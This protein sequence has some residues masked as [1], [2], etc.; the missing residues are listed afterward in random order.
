M[1]TDVPHIKYNNFSSCGGR[2]WL[3]G[4]GGV[5][6]GSIQAWTATVEIFRTEYRTKYANTEQRVWTISFS[7]VT[8]AKNIHKS[9]LKHFISFQS[10][11]YLLWCI[12]SYIKHWLKMCHL[13]SIFPNDKSNSNI[14]HVNSN[15]LHLCLSLWSCLNRL[16]ELFTQPYQSFY[17]FHVSFN[18]GVHIGHLH[19]KGSS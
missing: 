7:L 17:T 10:H 6:P 11:A 4:A 14:D 15:P 9:A 12:V 13:M 3:L 2:L 16:N 8:T 5:P 19:L 1:W 18:L